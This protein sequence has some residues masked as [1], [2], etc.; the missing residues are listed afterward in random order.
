MNLVLSLVFRW[1]HIGPAIVLVGGTAFML[2]VLLPAAKELPDAE[3]QKLRAAV[4][5]RWKQ[6]VHVG[7]GL[8]LISG[9]YNY[10]AIQGPLHKGDGMYHMLMGMKML[11]ALG[12][13]GIAEIM[14][15]RSKLADKF[16]QNSSKYLAI[17]LT[18]AVA[19]LM[20]SGFLKTRGI[21]IPGHE[22]E[23]APVVPSSSPG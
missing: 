7:I 22:L 16:R 4:L 8:F 15:G 12:V 18:L 5:K 10:L 2:F 21:P 23:V 20:L 13:F 17:N 1:L 3:H 19:I 9:F 14:V 6:F 11:M